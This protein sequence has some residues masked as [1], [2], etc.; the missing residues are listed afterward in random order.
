MIIVL[1]SALISVVTSTLPLASIPKH[2]VR[3]TGVVK[4]VWGKER[5][6]TQG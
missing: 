3:S 5:G 6:L 4:V 1:F 2:F